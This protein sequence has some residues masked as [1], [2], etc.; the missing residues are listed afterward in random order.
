MEMTLVPQKFFLPDLQNL[1]GKE[2]IIEYRKMRNEGIMVKAKSKDPKFKKNTKNT[3]PVFAKLVTS[4]INTNLKEGS[5]F[6]EYPEIKFEPFTWSNTTTIK[7]EFFTL[8]KLSS[9]SNNSPIVRIHNDRS[10][11]YNNNHPH[12]LSYTLPT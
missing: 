9:P 12:K 4:K 10:L 2:F 6:S 1:K 11:S 7:S 8:P 5:N 3:L